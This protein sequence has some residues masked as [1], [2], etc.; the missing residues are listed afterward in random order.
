VG[1]GSRDYRRP[2][3]FGVFAQVP[4]ITVL[5]LAWFVSGH[6][7]GGDFSIFRRAGEAVLE[8][9]TPYVHPTL[10]LLATN[11]RFVYPTPFAL[12]FIPFTFSPEKAAAVG[13]LFL[14]VAAVLGSIW[15]L[16]VR[17]WRCYGA[18]LLGLPVFG[19][20]G[21]GSIGPFLLLLCALGWRFRDR[22]VAGVPLALAA[23]AKLF[24]WPLLVWLLVTRRFRACAAALATIGATFALWASIDPGGMRRYPETIRLLNDVQ[25]WKSYSL[26]SLLISLHVSALASE[27]ATGVAAVAAVS[28]VVMLRRRGDRATFGAAVVAALIATPILW[29][30]YLM[31]LLAPIALA[32]PRLAPLWL[33]PV[34]L[35]VSPHPESLGIVWRIVLVL[36]V[37]GAVAVRAA[38]PELRLSKWLVSPSRK[39]AGPSLA[40]P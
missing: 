27:V 28:A 9:R 4:A 24:L 38:W 39:G 19:S 29:A 32:R 14:S 10:K 5:W 7:G 25:R 13:F 12:P 21:V 34:V 26:E 15:L 33:L 23:A 37:L 22:T 20:L 16:G 31:L 2:L 30:H 1:Q 18:S 6:G 17:D 40:P 11:D 36:A 3:E 35:W 8:G